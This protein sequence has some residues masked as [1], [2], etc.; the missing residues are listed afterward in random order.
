MVSTLEATEIV[1][2]RLDELDT[3]FL[4]LDID[5]F[6]RNIRAISG[7]LAEHGVAWRPHA[8]GHKSPVLA[9]RQVA[10]G[11]IGVTVAKVSEAEFMVAGGIESVLL[12]TEPGTPGKMARVAALQR[13]AEVI[14]PVDDPVQVEFASAAAVA[15]GVTIPIVIELD[16]GMHRCGVLQGEPALRLARLVAAM[17]GLR[18]AG[19]FGYEGHVLTV[20]PVADK[21][22]ATREAIGQL[23]STRAL[24]ESEGL[25]CP[26]VSTGGTGSFRYTATLPGITEIQ[27]GGG[28]LLDRFYTEQCHVEGLEYALTVRSSVVSR[29]APDRAVTDSGWKTMSI[30][31]GVPMV[32]DRPGVTVASLSAEHGVLAVAPEAADL[33]IGDPVTFIP[34]YHDST[35]VLHD[36]FIGVRDGLVVEV[37]PIVA[38]GAL[39]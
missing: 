10:A 12:V 21:E 18:F 16:I 29:P 36:R 5:R 34:G 14:V 22:A 28:S 33:A 3:P 23:A 9:R 13:S 1:G 26:I 32:V 15:A 30:S 17:P 31:H 4:V 35:V 27:A 38:R 39:A 8:K 7:A 37:F 20:W 24:L 25:P 6:E 19:I 11:A 2:R